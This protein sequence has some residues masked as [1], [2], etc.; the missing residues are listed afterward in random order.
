MSTILTMMNKLQTRRKGDLWIAFLFLVPSIVIFTIFVFYPL[1]YNF[2]LSTTSWNFLSP[3]KRFV[4][5]DNYQELLTDS[6]FWDVAGNTLWFA[7][8]HVGF[9]VVIGLGLALIL[10]QPIKGRSIFRMLLYFPNVTTTSA[11]ALLW[12]WIYD[13][14]FGPINYILNLLGMEGPHWLLNS[15]WAMWAVIIFSTWR[16]IGYVMLIYMGGLLSIPNYYYEAA[17]IDGANRIQAFF[18]ITL[19]LLSPTTFFILVTSFIGSLQVFDAIAVMT[20]GGPAATTKVINFEI[21]E[22]AFVEFD[23]GG[24]SALSVILFLFILAVTA[25][26]NVL[27]KRWVHYAAD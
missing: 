8:A 19:P 27:S 3:T 24:A 15:P 12:I 18:H 11:V 23:A 21:W 25:F 2:Y 4:G 10:N 9:S 7:T 14:R 20:G 6:R 26:Q 5:L 17:Q 22:K 16:S 13:F 1:V